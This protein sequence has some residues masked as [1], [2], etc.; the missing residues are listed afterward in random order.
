[1]GN[2][3]E[4]EVAARERKVD[5]C[6]L[7]FRRFSLAARSGL[8]NGKHKSA[9]F[10]F[11]C[12]CERVYTALV[13]VSTNATT[14]YCPTSTLVCVCM[15]VFCVK[16]R[17]KVA[18]LLKLNSTRGFLLQQYRIYTSY[19]FQQFAFLVDV[20]KYILINFTE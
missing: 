12:T 11:I 1:V 14:Y 4:D 13:L 15:C 5:L 2:G 19:G 7:V 8:I 10:G 20:E 16:K 6:T 3:E 17:I 9:K 18:N